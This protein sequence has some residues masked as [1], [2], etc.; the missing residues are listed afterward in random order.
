VPKKDDILKMFDAAISAV[1]PKNAINNSVNLD[2]NI[3]TVLEK[4]YN[5]DNYK[6]IYLCGSGKA[7]FLM[8]QE[9]ESILGSI[10]NSGIVVSPIKNVELKFSNH[11]Y[12]THPIPTQKSIDSSK[13]ML[14]E[15][16][17]MGSED[18]LIY[19]L[20]GGSSALLELPFSGITLEEFSKT[21]KILLENGFAIN[22]INAVRKHLSLVKGGRLAT[23]T[24][25]E[26]I[27]LVISDVIGDDLGSIASAPFYFDSTTFDDVYNLLKDKNVYTKLPL[28][29]QGVIKSGLGGEIEETPKKL[30]SNV[31]H[32]IISNNLSALKASESCAKDLGYEVKIIEKSVDGDVEDAAI[33]FVKDSKKLAKNQVLIQGGECTVNVTGSGVGG[34]NQHFALTALRELDENI[35][36]L[37]A[38]TDG[39]DGNSDDAGAVVSLD[40]KN[41]A[42]NINLSINEY[43]NNFN[44]NSFFKRVDSLISVG[45]TGTNVMDIMIAIRG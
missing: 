1:L 28:S 14:E 34:R 37:S 43:I 27:V 20:S 19:C 32:A 31:Y 13:K 33:E 7:S 21:T 11:H 41:S 29:V 9:I 3:L 6:N 15:L 35:T 5:L 17:K 10:I 38:G 16:E 44:S 23:A 2:K 45:Y 12:S 30:R 8:A 40:T 24:K 25:A 36:I 39:I 42:N 4:E 22:E 26:I 18:L